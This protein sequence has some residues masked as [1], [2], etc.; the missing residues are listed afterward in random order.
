[1]ST[2]VDLLY[3]TRAIKAWLGAQDAW[4]IEQGWSVQRTRWGGRR[5]HDPRWTERAAAMRKASAAAVVGSWAVPAGG[6]QVE[7]REW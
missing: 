4:A 2:F 7:G 3:P 5:Y 1:M 6:A